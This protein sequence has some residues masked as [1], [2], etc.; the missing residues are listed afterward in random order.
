MSKIINLIFDLPGKLQRQAR[1]K[2]PRP[3]RKV[4]NLV[5]ASVRLAKT[6][7]VSTIAAS[8]AYN[9]VFAIV[10][11]LAVIYVIFE[12]LGG[13]RFALEKVQP[14]LISTLAEGA[15]ETAQRTLESF[16][17]NASSKGMGW[18]GFGGLMFIALATY[19]RI[20]SAFQK[21]WAVQKVPSLTKRVMRVLLLLIVGP[22]LLTLSLTLTTAVA[23]QVAFVPWSGQLVAFAISYILFFMLY[24]LVPNVR[25]PLGTLAKGALLPAALWELTKAG[26]TIYTTRVVQYASLYGSLAAIPLFLLWIYLAWYI[27][28]F[29]AVWIRVL[30]RSR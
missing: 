8:L 6:T 27:A 17:Q 20:S 7:E 1:S 14:F 15:G 30:Q 10:P 25:V 23:A 29:G 12:Q 21:I 16:V 11:L 28:M 22:I 3:L 26:Y 13:L 18:V 2:T 9:T 19:T 4:G 5:L 24:S